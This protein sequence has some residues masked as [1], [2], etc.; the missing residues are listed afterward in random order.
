MKPEQK[1]IPLN[2]RSK[3]EQKEYHAAQRKDWGGLNPATRKIPNLKAYNRKKSKQQWCGHEPCLDF[4]VLEQF[5]QDHFK[6]KLSCR[7]SNI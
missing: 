4:L 7:K 3:G 6:L 5:K 1:F 2:K